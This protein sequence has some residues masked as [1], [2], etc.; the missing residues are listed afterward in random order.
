M[1]A[2]LVVYCIIT[3][4]FCSMS[5]IMCI[6]AGAHFFLFF[7]LFWSKNHIQ[8]DCVNLRD[9]NIVPIIRIW[10]S[11]NDSVTNNIF[12]SLKKKTHF[13]CFANLQSQHVNMRWPSWRD[14]LLLNTFTNTAYSHYFLFIYPNNKKKHNNNIIFSNWWVIAAK[15]D[16]IRCE[17]KRR[18]KKMNRKKKTFQFLYLKFITNGRM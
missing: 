3:F 4:Y 12:E 11:K 16:A 17:E 13:F 6:L 7:F 5:F 8:I 14:R 15:N 9:Q 2:L 18:I 1:S 10:N